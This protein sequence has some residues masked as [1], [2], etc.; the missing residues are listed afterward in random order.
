MY[1]VY[2]TQ[3]HKLQVIECQVIDASRQ[4]SHGVN[5]RTVVQ[6]PLAASHPPRCRDFIACSVLTSVM[7]SG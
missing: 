5:Y 7:H 6:L 3:R 2:I 4:I 1:I